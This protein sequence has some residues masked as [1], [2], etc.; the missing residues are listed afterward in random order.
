MASRRSRGI[1]HRHTFFKPACQLHKRCDFVQRASGQN[2]IRDDDVHWFG[3]N[4]LTETFF[5]NKA[6]YTWL[7]SNWQEHLRLQPSGPNTSQNTSCIHIPQIPEGEPQCRCGTHARGAWLGYVVEKGSFVVIGRI[8]GLQVRCSQR[9]SLLVLE[10]VSVRTIIVIWP[11]KYEFGIGSLEFLDVS[12]K[13][14]ASS[15]GSW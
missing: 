14:V 3:Y 1:S 6:L 9:V 15:F 5:W 13:R 12:W 2:C 10:T 11:P 4:L 7:S 8:Q